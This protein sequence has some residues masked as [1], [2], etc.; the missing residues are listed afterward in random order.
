MAT[1]S[2]SPVNFGAGRNGWWGFDLAKWP[3]QAGAPQFLDQQI[4]PGWS[5]FNITY[6]NS[7]APAIERDVLQQHSYGRQIG[8]VM[9]AV[10]VLVEQL[11][12]AA[13]RDKRVAEF[14]ALAKD[15]ER[16]KD[17]ARLPRLERL[18]KE[19]DALRQ[20]DPPAYERLRRTIVR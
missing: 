12:A 7:S 6:N 11:P 16:I 20:E 14:I 1:D 9:D 5:V 15:V 19:I 3:W 13:K 2:S 4:N 17:D 8:R 10:S 18:Q